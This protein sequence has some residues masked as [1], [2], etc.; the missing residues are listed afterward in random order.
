MEW[1]KKHKI[2]SVIL[3]LVLLGIIGGAVSPKSDNA[4]KAPSQTKQEEKK[5]PKAEKAAATL[6]KIGQSASD[7]KFEFIIKSVECNKQT[8]GTNQYLTKT[9]QGQYCIVSLSVKNVGDKAQ[10]F[11]S[12][13]Q[14]LLNAQGQEYSTD[15]VATSYSN[16]DYATTFSN[17]NPGN[18]VEGTIVFDIPKDQTPTIAELHDS[19]YSGGVKINLQ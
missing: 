6:P 11:F 19:A 12:A 7:G 14:K 4:A 1:F 16:P 18:T 17:I 15:D 5:E 9:A 13:N 2:I 10:P 3:V 8:V